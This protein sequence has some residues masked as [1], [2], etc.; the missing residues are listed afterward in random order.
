ML[1]RLREAVN[2]QFGSSPGSWAVH[3]SESTRQARP[4]GKDNPIDNNACQDDLSGVIIKITSYDN[5]K[6]G[7]TNEPNIA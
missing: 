3:R 4:S 5:T 2:V 6:Q 7:G 1:D